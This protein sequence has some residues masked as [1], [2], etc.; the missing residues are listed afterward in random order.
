MRPTTSQAAAGPDA[1]RRRGC[2]L[3][4]GIA[5]AALFAGVTVA[6]AQSTGIAACDDFLT[7]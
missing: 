4:A 7:K 1:I 2:S 5:G 3:A 6:H